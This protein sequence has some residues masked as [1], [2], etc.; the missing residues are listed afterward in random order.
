MRRGI[1]GRG[2]RGGVWRGRGG[3]WR[4]RTGELL[5]VGSGEEEEGGG[6]PVEESWAAKRSCSEEPSAGEVY[7]LHR[8]ALG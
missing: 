1:G 3:V 2:G 6:G 8:S 5:P 4:A 7:C